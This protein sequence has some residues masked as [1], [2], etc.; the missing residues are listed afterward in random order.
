LA[1]VKHF[2]DAFGVDLDVGGLEIAMNDG[3]RVRGFERERDLTRDTEGVVDG[4]RAARD[5]PGE[6]VARH[7][8]HDE[9]R[10]TVAQGA[11][12]SVEGRM[13]FDAVNLRDVRMV[14]RGR[15][16]CRAL[17]RPRPCRR[18][19]HRMSLSRLRRHCSQEGA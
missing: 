12:R 6:I 4:D 19:E 10:S 17:S 13:F 7:E 2:D 11:P 8:L 3:E 15:V 16:L 5:R 9:G 14:Q 18:H 1:E